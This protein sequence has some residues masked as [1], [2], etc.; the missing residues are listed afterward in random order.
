[1]TCDGKLAGSIASF[2]M[3]GQTEVIGTEVSYAAGRRAAIEETI[4]R[5]D[6]PRE[7]TLQVD[8]LL[9]DRATHIAVVPS[10]P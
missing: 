2:V 10:V 5:I 6:A 7:L 4:L 1:V 8:D 3:D 9:F